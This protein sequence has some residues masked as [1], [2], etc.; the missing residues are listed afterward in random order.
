MDAR[1]A[2]RERLRVLLSRPTERAI[3]DMRRRRKRVLRNLAE[4]A[5]HLSL[6]DLVS[7]RLVVAILSD[8]IPGHIGERA[9]EYAK[10]KAREEIRK[11]K[12]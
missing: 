12:G 6:E 3:E 2:E 9:R 1:E 8:W 5:E 7:V 11:A 4:M 10:K